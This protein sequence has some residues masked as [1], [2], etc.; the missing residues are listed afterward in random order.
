MRIKIIYIVILITG[1]LEAKPLWSQ[2]ADCKVELQDLQ[3]QYSGDCRK[4]FAHGKGTATGVNKYTGQFKDG[5]PDGKGVYYYADST[6]FDGNFQE[7]IREGKGELHL[8]GIDKTDSIQKGYW[9]GGKYV[10]KEYVTYVTN[11]QSIFDKFEATSSRRG[12]DIAFS[13]STTS[14]VFSTAPTGARS[15]GYLLTLSSVINLNGEP[16][17]LTSTNTTTNTYTAIY[18]IDKFP[19]ILMVTLS[20]GRSF[21]LELNKKASW[22]VDCYL[23]K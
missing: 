12:S 9:S 18:E 2:K 20:N 15:S 8:Q 23:N 7:G 5:L 6:Y 19:T 17:K 10:G 4:G 22:K 16:V 13:I 14:G 11:S 1:I 3:G 21:R